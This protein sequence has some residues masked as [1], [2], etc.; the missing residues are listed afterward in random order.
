MYGS[1]SYVLDESMISVS[2]FPDYYKMLEVPFNASHEEVKRA[3][4]H[5][6]ISMVSDDLI[7]NLMRH[8]E[9]EHDL[10]VNLAQ[11]I[12]AVSKVLG[13]KQQRAAYDQ[14][15]SSLS[16][17]YLTLQE[18]QYE[19]RIMTD[20]STLLDAFAPL[21][22]SFPDYYKMLVVPFNA[23][24]EEIKDAYQK[25]KKFAER[26]RE[27]MQGLSRQDGGAPYDILHDVN[28]AR[29]VLG[30]KEL[31]TAYDLIYLNLQENQDEQ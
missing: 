18:D 2:P 24:H 27:L 7:A 8:Y 1:H 3:Y 16:K 6:D 21:I 13:D 31:R 20:W 26:N 29:E 14:I 19:H 23:S 28:D 12:G 30:D 22:S 25:S 17:T 10:C 11:A 5:I 15:Y 9:S 4:E